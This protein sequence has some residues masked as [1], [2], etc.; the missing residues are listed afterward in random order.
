[1]SVAAPAGGREPGPLPLTGLTGNLPGFGPG[2][3]ETIRERRTM[4]AVIPIMMITNAMTPQVE[5][6]GTELSPRAA[7]P[8]TATSA[9]PVRTTL[10]VCVVLA[11]PSTTT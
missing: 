3:A 9:E 4:T 11:R 7:P 6:D 5:M 2:Q 8:N 1:M 10:N